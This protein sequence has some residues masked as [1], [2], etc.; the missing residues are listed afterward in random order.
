MALVAFLGEFSKALLNAVQPPQSDVSISRNVDERS[1]S[2]HQQS[3][4]TSPRSV[5]SNAAQRVDQHQ[6]NNIYVN[7]ASQHTILIMQA[8]LLLL[9]ILAGFVLYSVLRNSSAGGREG[10]R[11]HDRITQQNVLELQSTVAELRAIVAQ[12]KVDLESLQRKYLDDVDQ[13][14]AKAKAADARE[15]GKNVAIKSE[16]Q[17][18]EAII[19]SINSSKTFWRADETRVDL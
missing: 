17:S 16:I 11:E 13:R 12:L 9:L 18:L 1:L 14:L 6:A 4:T 19:D 10:E 7:G 15:G 3:T 8:T 2:S 5:Q